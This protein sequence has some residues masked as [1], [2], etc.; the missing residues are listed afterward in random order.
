[1]TTKLDFR[2]RARQHVKAAKEALAK[3]GEDAAQ[4]ACLKLRM[5]IEALTYQV[6]QAYLHEVPSEAMKQWTPKKV[7]SEMLEVDP[8]ADKSSKL[9]V[10][11]QQT[12]GIQ[13]H[14]VEYLGEDKRFTIKWG[15]KAHNALGNFLHEQTIAQFEKNGGTQEEAARSK[16]TEVLVELESILSTPM[17]QFNMG[18][19]VSIPCDC[20]VEVRRKKQALE[21][22]KPFSCGS[23]GKQYTYELAD[24][25]E[26]YLFQPEQVTYTCEGCNSEQFIAP[27]LL[28][29]LP[30]LVCRDCGS[31][32]QVEPTYSL[33][34][35]SAE[36]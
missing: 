25:G 13:T 30:V 16:A 17:M 32:A 27:H 5:A 19:F 14:N 35:L 24:D 11:K 4:Y 29:T 33:R 22:G 21:A 6:L 8:N 23:C 12:L 10:G 3:G 2:Y 34:L 1:M 31:K 7:M 28:E 18:E 15:N 9:F 26:N 36:Q 20:G